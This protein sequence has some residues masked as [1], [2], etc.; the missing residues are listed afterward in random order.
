MLCNRPLLQHKKSR[1]TARYHHVLEAKHTNVSTSQRIHYKTGKVVLLEFIGRKIEQENMFIIRE[2]QRKNNR[3]KIIVLWLSIPLG[4]IAILVVA[5]IFRYPLQII[6]GFVLVVLLL[7]NAVL[8][9]L[10]DPLHLSH[11]L[12]HMDTVSR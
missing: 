12:F 1:S 11:W 2:R 8:S 3:R 5:V 10:L 4:L 7:G 9:V 6:R